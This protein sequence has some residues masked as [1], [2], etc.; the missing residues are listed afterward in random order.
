MRERPSEAVTNR[1]H[2]GC[3]ER[4]QELDL[5]RPTLIPLLQA[6]PVVGVQHLYRDI[7]RCGAAHLDGAVVE[8]PLGACPDRQ[9]DSVAVRGVRGADEV[10]GLV[11]DSQAKR[12]RLSSENS[13]AESR[14]SA[15]SSLAR[16]PWK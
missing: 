10:L 14:C 12:S 3:L 7:K 2:P 9:A 5:R 1:H 8:H 11:H 4:A 15:S 13:P 16:G 6:G